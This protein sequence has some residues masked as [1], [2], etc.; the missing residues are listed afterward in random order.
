LSLSSARPIQSTPP[1]PVSPR[2]ILILYTYLR[3]DLPSDLFPSGFPTNNLK[4]FPF[5]PT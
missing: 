2:S 1:H 5:S 4:A 3:F